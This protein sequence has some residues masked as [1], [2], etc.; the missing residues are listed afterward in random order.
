MNAQQ[1]DRQAVEGRFKAEIPQHTLDALNGKA[2]HQVLEKLRSPA[3]V[4][5]WVLELVRLQVRTPEGEFLGKITRSLI[6]AR[7][8][9]KETRRKEHFKHVLSAD[10]KRLQR[11]AKD[12]RNLGMMA[13]SIF[14][15]YVAG[16][17]G[18]VD[19][20]WTARAAVEDA[21]AIM[22]EL[23]PRHGDASTEEA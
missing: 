5:E 12:E 2:S 15:G 14:A 6:E 22:R 11:D 20:E 13:A 4:G 1:T 23:A 7:A 18:A 3:F 21:E 8:V 10:A 16:K 17:R 19:R 9:L